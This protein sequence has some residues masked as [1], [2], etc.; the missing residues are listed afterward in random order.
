MTRSG[1]IVRTI[2][3]TTNS[4]APTQREHV[5]KIDIRQHDV[6]QAVEHHVIA[7]VGRIES[8]LNQQLLDLEILRGVFERAI[9]DCSGSILALLIR[10][11][12]PGQ[13]RPQTTV[14]R[15]VRLR[16]GGLF[17]GPKCNCQNDLVR[18]GNTYPAAP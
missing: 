2:S 11:S 14:G 12:P 5:G 16:G 7:D 9:E 6:H 13:Y 3:V 8:E 18:R 15:F 10:S 4:V 1:T 17:P